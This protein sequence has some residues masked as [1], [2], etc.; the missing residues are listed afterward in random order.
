MNIETINKLLNSTN[1]EDVRIAAS[2]VCTSISRNQVDT[3]ASTNL[4]INRE[5]TFLYRGE[6]F[7]LYIGFGVVWQ[8]D[9]DIIRTKIH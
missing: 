3:W 2:I 8:I 1:E 4:E 7:L 6:E 9:K 5:T